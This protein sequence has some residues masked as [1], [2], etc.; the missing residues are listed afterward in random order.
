MPD[1]DC[2]F[3]ENVSGTRRL[4]MLC[5]PFTRLGYPYAY[6]A[7]LSSVILTHRIATHPGNSNFL[8]NFKQS[9]DTV[10][11]FSGF[12]GYLCTDHCAEIHKGV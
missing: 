9:A 8:I 5:L 7:S 1:T 6:N 2:C 10:Y 4:R 12:S 3:M 11:I